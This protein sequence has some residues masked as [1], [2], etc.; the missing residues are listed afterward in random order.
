M[1][2][3]RRIAATFGALAVGLLLLAGCGGSGHGAA[4]PETEPTGAPSPV[5][6]REQLEAEI[7]TDYRAAND[8]Y[9]DA[10]NS[11]NPD[12]PALA[13]THTGAHLEKL[14]NRLRARAAAGQLGRDGPHSRDTS[15]ATVDQV[16]ENRIIVRD[17]QIDD[18]LLVTGSSGEIVDSDTVTRL[19]QAELVRVDGRWRVASNRALVEWDG[20]SGCAAS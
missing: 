10:I 1:R 9:H 2:R 12:L 20:V 17:C 6:T 13:A 14:R 18:G 15:R 3:D 8:A 11:G 19:L 16:L 4:R 7:L 5:T